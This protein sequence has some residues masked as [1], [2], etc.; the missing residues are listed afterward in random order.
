MFKRK[1]ASFFRVTFV[2]KVLDRTGQYHLGAKS[3]VGRMAVGTFN[4]AFLDGMV[5]LFVQLTPHIL[6]ACQTQ[7]RLSCFEIVNGTVVDSVTIAAGDV[8]LFVYS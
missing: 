8:V 1:G 2:T 3:T 7:I 5:C 4:L 6:V